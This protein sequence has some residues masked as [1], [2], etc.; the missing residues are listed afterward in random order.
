MSVIRGEGGGLLKVF[1]EGV[2]CENIDDIVR[3]FSKNHSEKTSI[4][5]R[6]VYLEEKRGISNSIQEFLQANDIENITVASHISPVPYIENILNLRTNERDADSPTPDSSQVSSQLNPL[7]AEFTPGCAWE[8]GK[9]NN[10]EISLSSSADYSIITVNSN[11][12]DLLVNP[13]EEVGLLTPPPPESA[14]GD[15]TSQNN[16]TEELTACSEISDDG[17]G[18]GN[19]HKTMD[20]LKIHLD[21]IFC[22]IPEKGKITFNA[23][24]IKKVLTSMKGYSA[25]GPSSENKALY[26][27]LFELLPNVFTQAFV[28]LS[29]IENFYDSPFSYLMKRNIVFIPKGGRIAEPSTSDYRPISL[30]ETGYKILA[31]L[32]THQ[33][34]PFIARITGPNQFGFVPGRQ[35]NTASHT[36]IKLID[37]MKR[38]DVQGQICFLDIKSAFDTANINSINTIME[39]IFPNSDLPEKMHALTRKGLAKVNIGGTVGEE[40]EL[41]MGAGQGDPQSSFRYLVL[42]TYFIEALNILMKKNVCEALPSFALKINDYQSKPFAIDGQCFAD[43][44]VICTNFINVSQIKYF[45]WI[46]DQLAYGTGLEINLSKTKLLLFGPHSQGIQRQ[47]KQIGK[48]TDRVKHLGITITP[49]HDL[50]RDY[51]YAE[52]VERVKTA[53]EHYVKKSGSGDILNKKQ[54]VVSIIASVAQFAFRAVPPKE[55]T[56]EKIWKLTVDALWHY[57]YLGNQAGRKKVATKRVHF[58]LSHGGL[59]LAKTQSINFRASIGGLT[60]NLGYCFNNKNCVLNKITG[61][62]N[63]IR[64][65]QFGS[66]AVDS[67]KK[68]YCNA[69]PV[70][71]NTITNIKTLLRNIETNPKEIL[72]HPLIGGV[73]APFHAITSREIT[74]TYPWT[75]GAVLKLEVRG[76]FHRSYN[77]SI[78]EELIG[79]LP[80]LT[81]EKVRNLCNYVERK[82]SLPRIQKLT[83]ARFEPPFW[84]NKAD[85]TFITKYHKRM[86]RRAHL[87]EVPPSYSSRQRDG[88]EVPKEVKVFQSAFTRLKNIKL[89]G[90]LKSFQF[91]LLWRTL[92]SKNKLYNMGKIDS[93]ECSTCKVKATSGHQAVDCIIPV[94]FRYILKNNKAFKKKLDPHTFFHNYKP[95]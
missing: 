69:M 7:A 70:G 77:Y 28:A 23:D 8:G 54:M 92:P 80:D 36:I 2:Q 33:L 12:S 18:R 46:L 73:N 89:L 72:R 26:M 63:N 3:I 42:H 71:E 75:V 30:L 24:D 17:G 32:Y 74:E 31:K 57:H 38:Q 55:E 53:S 84:M 68:Y 27:F 1:H 10:S 60:S 48:I 5:V 21:D 22:K 6:Q 82:F 14:A 94:F 76:R 52:I 44:T 90:E 61:L 79:N 78:N 56:L 83:Q 49:E 87:Q 45:R 81:K 43:D 15:I 95:C 16:K 25:P 65:F 35:M 85:K 40:F 41:T 39:F 91:E 34:K 9:K 11:D 4:H 66:R 51:T 20:T 88:E 50:T 37:E 47:L 67:L 86:E 13:P 93:N 29:K 64:V 19:L 62:A 58:P 59:G